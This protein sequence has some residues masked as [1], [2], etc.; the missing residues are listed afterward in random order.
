MKKLFF[1][2]SDVIWI[3]L[4]GATSGLPITLQSLLRL[5]NQPKSGLF[6]KK[7]IFTNFLMNFTP[8][9]VL[10]MASNLCCRFS[11]SSHLA[12]FHFG[13]NFWSLISCQNFL[14]QA[15]VLLCEFCIK[16]CARLRKVEEKCKRCFCLLVIPKIFHSG[17]SGDSDVLGES[18]NIGDSK[19]FYDSGESSGSTYR[20]WRFW[21]IWWFWRILM[22]VV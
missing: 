17:G 13:G 8:Q 5:P 7:S 1:W 4:L 3:S 9:K 11:T 16:R 19:E 12:S 14:H 2:I 10:K 18:A 6:E 22:L 15:S 20:I 21:W